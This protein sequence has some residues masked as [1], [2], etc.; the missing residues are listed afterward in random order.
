M[1]HH[2]KRLISSI[3]FFA[4][5]GTV[6]TGTAL[7][8]TASAQNRSLAGLPLNVIETPNFRVVFPA[9]APASGNSAPEKLALERYARRVA[10]GL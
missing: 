1:T 3:T 6:L 2:F 7:T 8:G 4:L 9:D 5:I 10:A